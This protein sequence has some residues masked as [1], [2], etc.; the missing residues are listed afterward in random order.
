M[1]KEK[2]RRLEK[3]I[4]ALQCFFF[5][6]AHRQLFTVFFFRITSKTM[7]NE[8]LVVGLYYQK[9]HRKVAARTSNLLPLIIYS[10]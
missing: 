3:L 10:L 8:S 4:Y 5:R 7:G 9:F 2:K 6:N 1:S